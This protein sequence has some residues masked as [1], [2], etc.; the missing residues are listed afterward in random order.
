MVPPNSKGISPVPPYSGFA[1]VQNLYSYRALTLS[2]RI[3]QFVQIKLLSK[4]TSYN[5]RFAVTTLVW[6]SPCSLATTYGITIVLFSS[7]YLDVSVQQVCLLLLQDDGSSN[8]RVAPFGNLRIN[9]FVQFPVAY[10][11]L[12]RPSSPPRA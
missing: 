6:A 10:R 11:S 9:T 2:R 7:A 1:Y 12:T 4:K 8:H 3:S 5:P